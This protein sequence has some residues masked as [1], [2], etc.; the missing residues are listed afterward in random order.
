MPTVSVF[1]G[2]TIAM[3]YDEHA[4]PHFHATY[5]GDEVLINIRTLRTY[6]GALPRRAMKLVLEW[7]RLHQAELLA[8]W[9]RARTGGTIGRIAPLD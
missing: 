7:A 9:D 4:P 2:I 6:K 8:N 5:G 1:Y 3:F